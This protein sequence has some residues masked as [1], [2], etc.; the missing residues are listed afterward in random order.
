MTGP[1]TPSFRTCKRTDA[2]V[3]ASD[4]NPQTRTRL[5]GSF[6]QQRLTVSPNVQFSGRVTSCHA[7]RR[8]ARVDVSRSAATACYVRLPPNLPDADLCGLRRT[9]RRDRRRTKGTALHEA[10]DVRDLPLRQ[11]RNA[12]ALNP[13]WQAQPMAEAFNGSSR[14]TL[15]ATGVGAAETKTLPSSPELPT[16]R[17]AQRSG[18]CRQLFKRTLRRQRRVNEEIF[19][20]E[21]RGQL[22]AATLFRIRPHNAAVQ[23]PRAAV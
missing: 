10:D 7:R 4:N 18:A 15:R 12:A 9:L 17:P 21:R 23:R 14:L 2:A 13:T 5:V 16:L 6:K 22:C 20:E 11:R 19:D 8:R 3:S 1:F